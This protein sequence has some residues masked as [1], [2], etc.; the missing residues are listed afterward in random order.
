M[1][2]SNQDGVILGGACSNEQVLTFLFDAVYGLGFISMLW[3]MFEKFFGFGKK[4]MVLG[5]DEDG[6]E[7]LE[8]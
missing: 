8:E 6:N 4:K 3:F 7:K 2:S 1:A 5:K